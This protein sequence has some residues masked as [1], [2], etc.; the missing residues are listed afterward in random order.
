MTNSKTAAIDLFPNG[1]IP[2]DGY[3]LGRIYIASFN[4]TNMELEVTN[5]SKIV[6]AQL[7][8]VGGT[9]IVTDVSGGTAIVAVTGANG[10]AALNGMILYKE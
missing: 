6:D 3:K 7:M 4:P 5:A 10:T 2:N 1:G 9:A 8:N